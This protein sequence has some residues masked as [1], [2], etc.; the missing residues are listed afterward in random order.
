MS[1]AR[2]SS[3]VLVGALLRLAERSGG[4]GT[5]LTRGDRDSGAILLLVAERGRA[6]LVLE[7][8]LQATGDYRW[9]EAARRAA[10]DQNDKAFDK[11]LARRRD[12]D[13]DS[14]ILELDVA[15]AER[16]TAEIMNLD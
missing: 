16:L 5:V 10:G 14:W 11:F 8:V 1:S 6:A 9:T 3:E 13:P 7:R 15:S 4:F 12:F 2:L